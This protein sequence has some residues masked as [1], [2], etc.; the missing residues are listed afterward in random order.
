MKRQSWLGPNVR[1]VP[2]ALVAPALV[3]AAGA[4]LAVVAHL[5]VGRAWLIGLGWGIAAWGVVSAMVLTYWLTRPRLA[6]QDAELLVNLRFGAPVRVPVQIVEC[7]FLGRAQSRMTPSQSTSPQTAA[8]V[9]RL[10]ESATA[11]HR[12]KVTR[13]LGTWQDGYITILGTWCEPLGGE[14]LGRLNE[15]LVRAHREQRS[16]IDKEAP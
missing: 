14:L 12:A 8:L 15:R 16:T 6:Y 3:F 4:A 1:A 13:F 5:W 2:V 11:Y 7:F 10:A 9:V